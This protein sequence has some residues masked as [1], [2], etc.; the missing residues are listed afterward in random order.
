MK[1][2][3]KSVIRLKYKSI[4]TRTAAWKVFL[5]TYFTTVKTVQGKDYN[6]RT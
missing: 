4:E 1:K 2:K 5:E 3:S 6:Y